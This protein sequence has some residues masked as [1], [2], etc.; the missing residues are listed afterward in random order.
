MSSSISSSSEEELDE[1][2]GTTW[3][4]PS[5]VLILCRS[6]SPI[7]DHRDVDVCSA[8]PY[9]PLRAGMFIPR[10]PMTGDESGDGCSARIEWWRLVAAR[11]KS[12]PRERR[13]KRLVGEAY[14]CEWSSLGDDGAG[15]M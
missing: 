3:L 7:I 13:G 4:L 1:S 5:E 10:S 2:D 12:R 6:W 14:V 11:E 8:P 9:G 15:R